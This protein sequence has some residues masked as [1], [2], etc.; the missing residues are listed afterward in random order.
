MHDRMSIC[1]SHGTHE[2]ITCGTLKLRLDI[3]SSR[4]FDLAF[5]FFHLYVYHIT[6]QGL[7]PQVQSI[8]TTLYPLSLRSSLTHEG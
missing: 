8:Y 7:K 2:I 3:I 5:P 1:L 6:F 4:I